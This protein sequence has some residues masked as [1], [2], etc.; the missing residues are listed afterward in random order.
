MKIFKSR[1]SKE[2]YFEKVLR[3]KRGGK[4]QKAQMPKIKPAKQAAT[5]KETPI[6]IYNWKSPKDP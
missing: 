3:L 5:T 4:Q 1:P 6:R 2:I